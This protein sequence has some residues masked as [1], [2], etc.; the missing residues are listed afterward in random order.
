MPPADTRRAAGP[1]ATVD[2]A[3]AFVLKATAT[4]PQTEAELRGKLAGREAPEDVVD[5][6]IARA[7]QLGAVDDRAFARAWVEDRGLKRGYGAARLRREL[8]RRLVPD[9]LVEEALALLDDHD[10]EAHAE[11]LARTAAQ[12]YPAQLDPAKVAQRLVGFLV[13]RGYPPGLAQR[14]AI[15]VSGLDRHW[16]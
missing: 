9:P 11:E 10:E 15:R 13:R 6:A 1:V 4:R 3:V 7:R 12:R 5:R 14:V 16:D 8:R 2:A